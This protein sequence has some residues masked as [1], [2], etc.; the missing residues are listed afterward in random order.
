MPPLDVLID[1]FIA[2]GGPSPWHL[3]GTAT[4]RR[5]GAG[6]NGERQVSLNCGIMM[7]SV[8]ASPAQGRLIAFGATAASPLPL[9]FPRG[10]CVG[11]MAA[12]PLRA[13]IPITSLAPEEAPQLWQTP[14][15]F[16]ARMDTF[17]CWQGGGCD[18]KN[19]GGNVQA[20]VAA[21]ACSEQLKESRREEEEDTAARRRQCCRMV[22]GWW[23]TRQGGVTRGERE[24]DDRKR[25]G[26][27]TT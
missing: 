26:G 3:V 9:R 19:G 23:T 2:N 4:A 7:L 20:L 12:A 24:A 15:F 6:G 8:P 1:C 11:G 14:C 16:L 5:D 27:Q 25:G 22:G 13:R 21:R 10:D 17:V 18:D